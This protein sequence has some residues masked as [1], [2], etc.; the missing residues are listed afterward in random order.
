MPVVSERPVEVAAARVV[1]EAALAAG[2]G[3]LELT[4]VLRRRADR[5]ELYYPLDGHWNTGGHAAAAAAIAGYI[6]SREGEAI[7]GRVSRG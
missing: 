1:E 2:A 5:Y 7:A 3:F 4:P 6:E